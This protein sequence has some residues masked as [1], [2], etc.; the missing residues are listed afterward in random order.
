MNIFVMEDDFMQQAR[1][2]KI[3]TKLLEKHNIVPKKFEISGKPHQLLQAIEK[4]GVH[5]LFFLDIEIKE[6]ELKGLQVAKQIRE[7]DPYASIVF[8]TKLAINSTFF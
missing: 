6:D 4:K 1:I 2:E 7:I 8:V 5:Q 3:I